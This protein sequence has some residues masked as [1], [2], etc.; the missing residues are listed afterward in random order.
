M[1]SGAKRLIFSEG[2]NT[3]YSQ[4]ERVVAR[5]SNTL[6]GMYVFT[7]RN[8]PILHIQSTRQGG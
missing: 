7:K 1:R 3:R 8:D 4:R 2:S 5:D 6:V